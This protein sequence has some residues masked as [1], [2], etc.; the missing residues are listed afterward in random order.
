MRAELPL[1]FVIRFRLAILLVVQVGVYM[2]PLFAD[3]TAARAEFPLEAFQ[4]SA[5]D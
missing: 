1:H 4:V 3:W 2:S 5:V